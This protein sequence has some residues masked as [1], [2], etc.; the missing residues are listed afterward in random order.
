MVAEVYKTS[1]F[2]FESRF[3]G[4]FATSGR[5]P[6]WG[7]DCCGHHAHELGVTSKIHGCEP[8]GFPHGNRWNSNQKTN[9]NQ[10]KPIK[11]TTVYRYIYIYSFPYFCLVVFRIFP[12]KL[13][14][15]TSTIYLVALIDGENPQLSWKRSCCFFIAG[16]D[17]HISS[18]E[19]FCSTSTWLNF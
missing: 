10:K 2:C 15:T 4:S 6:N 9:K 1:V 8:R 19:T 14:I 16:A 18:G 17:L 12:S 3:H 11:I 13:K 5:V 7:P